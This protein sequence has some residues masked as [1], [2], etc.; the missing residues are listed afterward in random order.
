RRAGPS[1][2]AKNT[3][4][5]PKNYSPSANAGALTALSLVGT[6]GAPASEPATPPC[7]KSVPPKSVSPANAP[8]Q[9]AP[10]APAD[11]TCSGL[12]PAVD[13]RLSSATLTKNR[14]VGH[15]YLP[16]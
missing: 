1:P 11:D 10:R 2:T 13:H 14:G 6:C 4:Q 7:A 12:L 5:S 9:S 8:S 3:C 16:A 15:R